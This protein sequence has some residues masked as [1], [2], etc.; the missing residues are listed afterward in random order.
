MSKI[1]QNTCSVQITG[2]STRYSLDLLNLPNYCQKLT[3]SLFKD[4][5]YVECVQLYFKESWGGQHNANVVIKWFLLL[6]VKWKK[7]LK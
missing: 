5:M 1:S 3:L 4:L 7:K 2:V 6:F